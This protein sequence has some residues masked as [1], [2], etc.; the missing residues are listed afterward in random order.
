MIR[1]ILLLGVGAALMG[2]GLAPSREWAPKDYPI[3]FWCGPPDPHIALEQY[4][5][6]A[7]A[8]FTFVGPPCEGAA[9]EER[10]KRILDMSKTVGI[11]AM[12]QDSRMPL[13][14]GSDPDAKK[15]IDAIVAAYAK[16][17]GL[18]GYFIT[19]EPGAAAFP[20]LAEVVAYLRQKDP[21][22]PAYINLLPTYASPEQLGTPTYREHVAQYIKTVSPFA[23][24]YD[25]YHFLKDADRP[26]FFT[27]LDEVRRLS[28][29]YEL[30]FWQ[31]VLSI[32][33]GPY[34]SL[35]EAEK[36]WEA[37]QTLAFGAKGVMFFTYWTPNDPSFDW[38]PA[39]IA[40]DGT[41]TRQYDE[42][43]RIN[44]D[45]RAIGAYL[46]QAKQIGVFTNG[47]PAPEVF[48]R[49][50]GLP[51]KIDGTSDVTVGVF[52]A[53]TSLYV[54]VANRDYKKATTAAA[55]LS[56]DTNKPEILD[57]ATGKWLPLRT[58][59]RPEG[60]KGASI[61]IEAGDAQLIRW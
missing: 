4:R 54:L 38:K 29:R 15:R 52:R 24:S 6:I 7:Q 50:D 59:A 16:H 46:L 21:N 17:P 57:R 39:I 45:V 55:I 37:M 41:P 2:S 35:T 61:D 53:G 20:G 49:E 32:E 14:I 25:H 26:G 5:R 27:N 56:C 28:A 12:V 48:P 8:G 19:D 51:V 11:K 30:P 31:I 9:T 23:V 33:H 3:G 36:R 34:R 40:K 58:T 43:K 22:H 47:A 44:H 13:S 42:V 18:M 60:D 10:N 1:L